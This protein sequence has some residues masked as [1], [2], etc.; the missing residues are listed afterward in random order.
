MP[1]RKVIFEHNG[2]F[3]RVFDGS[4]RSKIEQIKGQIGFETEAE[5]K[6]KRKK[7]A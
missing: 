7:K 1:T 5:A 6:P 4:R 3:Y 2:R